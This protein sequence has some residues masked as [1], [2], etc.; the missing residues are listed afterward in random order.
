MSQ[1]N[2]L[3]NLMD[4]LD[5]I[6]NKCLEAV[7]SRKQAQK[8]AITYRKAYDVFMDYFDELSPESRLELDKKL[9]ELGL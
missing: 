4:N 7:E 8:N 5:F 2:K 9:K 3:N 6:S 1:K